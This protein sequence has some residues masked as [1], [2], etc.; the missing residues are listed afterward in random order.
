MYKYTVVAISCLVFTVLLPSFSYAQNGS[1]PIISVSEDNKNNAAGVSSFAAKVLDST[2]LVYG[3][4]KIFL[5]GLEKIN[6]ED[7]SFHL[8]ARN[9]LEKM[10]GNASVTCSIK[11]KQEDYITAQCVNGK[12]EDLGLFL[13]RSGNAIVDRLVI[14]NSVY[15]KPYLA[16]ESAAQLNM[17][18]VWDVGDNKD[19]V[20]QGFFSLGNDTLVKSIMSAMVAFVVMVVIFIIYI[21]RGFSRIVAIQNKSISLAAKERALRNK[22]KH[23]IACM[24]D[25]EIKTNKSKIEAYLVIYEATLREFNVRDSVPRYQKT[26]EVVQKSPGLGRSVFD[27]NVDKINL[28]GARMASVIIHYYARIKTESDYIEIP[29]DMPQE[30]AQYIIENIVANAKKLNEIS[31]KLISKFTKLDSIK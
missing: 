25:A 9:A 29:P 21:M 15:E 16:A 1:S 12:E 6:T 11:D 28:F 8:K 26:G 30:E 7:T 4:T 13:L 27:G 22:E 17:S 3:S 23:V 5:W 10:V 2:T 20:S 19:Q 24:I 31:D 18:G 14:Y